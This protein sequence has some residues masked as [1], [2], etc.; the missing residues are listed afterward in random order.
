M[1]AE[2][3]CCERVRHRQRPHPLSAKPLA[4]IQGLRGIAALL[5]VLWHASR[6][7]GPYGTGTG[8]SLFAPGGTLGVDLFFLISG[9]IMVHTTRNND[10]SWKYFVEFAIKRAT[11]IW[12]VWI[13]AVAVYMASRADTAFLADP[14]QFARLLHSLAFVP[15]ADAP[16]DVPPVYGFPVLNVGWTLNYE[17][18]FYAFFGI[19]MLFGRWRWVAFFAWLGATLLVIP[20]ATG[21]LASGSDW[22]RLLS[23]SPAHQPEYSP[24]YLGLVSNP[25]ILMFVA[26]VVI[27]LIHRSRFVIDSVPLLAVL[28][29]G[30][31]TGVVVQYALPFRS[32]H[33]LLGWGLSL[34]PLMLI[35]IVASKRIP[36]PTPAWLVY[37]GDI[38]FSLYLFHPTVQESFDRVALAFGYR[39]AGYSAIV[40]TTVLSIA[41]A[42]VA[43]RCIERGLCERLKRWAL[44]RDEST[45]IAAI[46]SALP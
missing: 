26:G 37:A 22:I 11:R 38:S 23:L 33:G 34:V 31:A 6:Y 8:G 14:V 40:V 9:F 46:A 18:Y 32:D 1:R 24:R 45:R 7:L 20:Y 30:A 5:V 35:L 13:V 25:L 44:R 2:R 29:A 21:H 17:M 15:T 28:A 36:L 42:D 4:F 12:P 39:P 27:G 3:F 10:A 43:H 16:V 19:A 41:V